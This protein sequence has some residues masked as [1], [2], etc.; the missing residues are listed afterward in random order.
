MPP[1]ARERAR[2][3]AWAALCQCFDEGNWTS[4]PALH[5][6]VLEELASGGATAAP[7]WLSSP[8]AAK[9]LV[10]GEGAPEGNGVAPVG[11]PGAD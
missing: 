7:A 6:L 11:V 2:A 9:P 10:G 3:M 4:Y 1:D 8:E 5:K